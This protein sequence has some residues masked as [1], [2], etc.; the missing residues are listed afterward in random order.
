MEGGLV[1]DKERKWQQ[2]P[3]LMRLWRLLSHATMDMPL[4]LLQIAVSSV[5]M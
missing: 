2:K 4:L 5:R 3:Y 1:V